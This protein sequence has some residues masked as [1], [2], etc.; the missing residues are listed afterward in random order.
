[1]VSRTA[2]IVLGSLG[3]LLA[4]VFENQNIAYMV[5]LAFAVSASTNF[6]ILVLTLYWRGLTT[7]GV[8]FGG[9]VGL[10]STVTLLVL[11]PT[12]W[13]DI[14][15]YAEPIFPYKYPALITSP[16]AFAAIYLVSRL[17]NSVRAV[18]DRE[19][20]DGQ[21]KAAFGENKA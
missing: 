6:P 1:M 5:S 14:L 2:I 17:D 12:V 9:A 18:R 21:C 4:F 11:G 8:V 15:G 10:I 3:I 13:V 20:F 19:G 16:V 7:R